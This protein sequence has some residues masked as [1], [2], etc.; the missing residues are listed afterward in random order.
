MKSYDM[1]E[2]GDYKIELLEKIEYEAKTE[3]FKREGYYIRRHRDICVNKY[4]AG[5]TDKQYKKDN[6]QYINQKL[7]CVCGRTYT[8]CHKARHEKTNIHIKYV[9]ENRLTEQSLVDQYTL[10]YR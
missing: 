1:L 4:I 3:L 9:S 6:A 7:E 8:R 10:S 5:R 2:N